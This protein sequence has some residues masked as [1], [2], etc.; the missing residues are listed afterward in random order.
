[1]A[2]FQGGFEAII[3][4]LQLMTS[5]ERKRIISDMAKKDSAMAAA[6]ESKLFGIRDLENITDKMLVEFLQNVDLIDLA[7]SMKLQSEDFV[8]SFLVRLPSRMAVE[9]KET[10]DLKKV[11]KRDAEASEQK[12]LKVFRQMIDQGKLIISNDDEYV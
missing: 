4:A 10:M 6:I 8:K 12:V 1:M 11:P 2:K 3:K 9:I 7:L 5:A